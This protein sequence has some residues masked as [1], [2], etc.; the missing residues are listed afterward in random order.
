MSHLTGLE[1][2]TQCIWS[3]AVVAHTFN[4]RIQEEGGPLSSR[5]VWSEKLCMEKKKRKTKKNEE[6]IWNPAQKK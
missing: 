1:N 4:P 6:C 2:T 5:S 3:Q